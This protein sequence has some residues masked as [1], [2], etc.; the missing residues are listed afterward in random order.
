MA[1][2]DFERMTAGYGISGFP[3]GL[4]PLFEQYAAAYAPHPL[5][6]RD[7]LKEL[8]V[9]FE[10][11]A[12]AQERLLS[13]LAEIEENPELLLLSNFLAND[14]CAARHRLDMD[15]Y[16]AIEL[17]SGMK[18][19][20]LFSCLLLFACIEPSMERLA[21]LGVPRPEY[22]KVPFVPAKRQLAKLRDTGDGRVSDFPWDMNF[23]TCSLFQ[24]GR[25]N[26][27][28]FRLD[29]P[30]KVFRR[31]NE[32]VA[33]FT[34]PMHIRRDGQL[35]GVNGQFDPEAFEIRY[36]EKNGTAT[37]W[38][39]CPAGAVQRS[40]RSLSL[41]EW[42]LVLQEGDI[43]MGFHIPGGPGYDPQHLRDDSL[44]CSAF[45][46]KWFPE[47][48]VKGFGSESW[49]YDPHLAMVLEGRGNIPAM[50]RQMYIYPIASGDGQFFGELFGKKMPLANAPRASRLQRSAAE[51]ME[52]GG[53]FTPCSMF[54][55]TDDLPR[56]GCED[57]YACEADYKAVWDSLSDPPLYPQE[58]AQV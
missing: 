19:A 18:N 5:L 38:P 14:M 33:F 51:Y 3:E 29:D 23:Y 45:Y 13:G 20:D 48:D 49:L 55:L 24:I 26:F 8:C 57:I 25:F 41:N 54:I 36:E 21:Q 42:E 15:D 30:L 53:R 56:V 16:A 4:A 35:D 58:G 50:Q 10:A 22:E 40:P 28:P 1:S 31:G 6:R 47:I 17:K 39:I 37:G 7:F 44:K 46:S 43:L 32:T 27:I 9:R 11:G 12:A 2:L 34:Q 52:K